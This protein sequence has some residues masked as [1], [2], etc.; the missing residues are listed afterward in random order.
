MSTYSYLCCFDCEES[1]FVKDADT[2]IHANPEELGQFFEKHYRHSLR[3]L[4]EDDGVST[5][6]G[7]EFPADCWKRFKLS[8]GGYWSVG[9]FLEDHQPANAYPKPVHPEADWV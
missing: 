4:H 9:R 7:D 3:F 8:S 6:R 2:P 5:L 1:I